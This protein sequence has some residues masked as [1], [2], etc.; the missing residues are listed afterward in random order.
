MCN[1][2]SNTF[3]GSG[4]PPISPNEDKD[5]VKNSTHI[6]LLCVKERDFL[7]CSCHVFWVHVELCETRRQFVCRRRGSGCWMHVSVGKTPFLRCPMPKKNN[8]RMIRSGV[9]VSN[10]N[11]NDVCPWY[12]TPADHAGNDPVNFFAGSP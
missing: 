6:I 8:C 2:F 9:R 10:L 4:L 3:C 7:R 12:L 5:S 1:R 11:R